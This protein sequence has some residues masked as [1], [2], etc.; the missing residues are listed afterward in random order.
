[1]RYGTVG[2]A[3]R[4]LVILLLASTA[5]RAQAVSTAQIN[6]TVKDGG[7]LAL[8]GVTITDT[9]T[10]TSLTRTGVTNDTGSDTLTNLPIELVNNSLAGP[11]RFNVDMGLTRSFRVGGERCAH[12]S[13]RAEVHVLRKADLKVRL[14]EDG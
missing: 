11:S 5:V 2:V 14:Y 8:P 9:Q 12:H 10:D 3:I 1:M 7:G 6:W 4:S 13:A